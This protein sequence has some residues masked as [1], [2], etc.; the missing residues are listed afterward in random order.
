MTRLLVVALD[1][2]EHDVVGDSREQR[3]ELVVANGTRPQVNEVSLDE[4]REAGR[5]LE[6]LVALARRH[7][8]SNSQRHQ[9]E[10]ARVLGVGQIVAV[11]VKEEHRLGRYVLNVAHECELGAVCAEYALEF[12]VDGQFDAIA[13]AAVEQ[14]AVAYKPFDVTAWL[15]RVDDELGA[16]QVRVL[17]ARQARV[18]VEQV[19]GE[20]VGSRVSA[21]VAHHQH[22]GRILGAL[23]TVRKRGLDVCPKRARL[24]RILALERVEVA[25]HALR[26]G[27]SRRQCGR[28]SRYSCN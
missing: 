22:N 2:D 1:V 27:Y 6:Q 13:A 24:R 10:H 7:L 26:F 4:V 11:R 14:V 19:V 9:Y 18:Q 5:A 8:A 23:H 25:A 15:E 21:R 20:R 16:R 12:L 17:I 3:L 28:R